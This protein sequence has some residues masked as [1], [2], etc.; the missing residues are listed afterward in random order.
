LVHLQKQQEGD[1]LDVVAVADTLVAQD[2]GKIP[3]LGDQGG[4]ISCHAQSLC[5]LLLLPR[6]RHHFPISLPISP[7]VFIAFS[8]VFFATSETRS[9]VDGRRLNAADSTAISS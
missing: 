4:V 9:A 6:P 5:C 8:V 7:A 2:V 1:L 3:D